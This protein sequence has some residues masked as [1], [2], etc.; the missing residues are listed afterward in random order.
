MIFS[1]LFYGFLIY[2]LYR[3]VFNFIIPIYRTT[4]QVKKGF[5]E[6]HERM[7]QQYQQNGAH[8]QTTHDQESKKPDTNK[9]GEYIDFEEVK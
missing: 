2:L 1:I 3:L 8:S 6:M 5:R 4:K 9:V 7:N